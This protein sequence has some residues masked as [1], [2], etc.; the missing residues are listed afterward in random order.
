MP[1]VLLHPC[2][3]YLSLTRCLPSPV[4]QAVKPDLTESRPGQEDGGGAA[5]GRR[6]GGRRPGNGG[7]GRPGGRPRPG[8]PYLTDNAVEGSDPAL[9]TVVPSL[10]AGDNN[11]INNINTDRGPTVDGPNFDLRDENGA[12]VT[13]KLHL[14]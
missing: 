2:H 12:K 3:P 13:D 10:E 11:H 7:G 4:D 14:G 6:P 5:G 8:P 1:A 9:A